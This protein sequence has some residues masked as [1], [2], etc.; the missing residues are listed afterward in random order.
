MNEMETVSL[1]M[2]VEVRILVP[3][4]MFQICPFWGLPIALPLPQPAALVKVK[5]V[6]F[7]SDVSGSPSPGASMIHSTQLPSNCEVGGG[8]R[9]IEKFW[10]VVTLPKVIWPAV[11]L[12][13][14]ATAT[15]TVWPGLRAKGFLL[16][17][18]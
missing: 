12:L 14:Y 13:M 7:G 9:M 6:N 4:S 15:E 1:P 2:L 17:S 3:D 10:P 5:G 8:W 16:L 18:W 11:L